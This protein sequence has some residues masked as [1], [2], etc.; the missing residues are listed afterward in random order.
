MSAIE[1]TAIGPLSRIIAFEKDYLGGHLMADVR[2][3]LSRIV[4]NVEAR[5]EA[6]ACRGGVAWLD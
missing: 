3:L 2:P 5:S 1:R 4:L 6:T